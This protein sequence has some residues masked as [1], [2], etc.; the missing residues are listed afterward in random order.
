MEHLGVDPEAALFAVRTRSRGSKINLAHDA[1]SLAQWS[2]VVKNLSAPT[3][4]AFEALGDWLGAGGLGWWSQGRPS[5]AY[6]LRPGQ[7]ATHLE[8]AALWDS[9]GRPPITHAQPTSARPSVTRVRG[10]APVSASY[11][12]KDDP[13]MME[14]FNLEQAAFR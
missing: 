1:R 10:P 9:S 5:L 2:T 3:L 6:L 13:E 11:A 14:I 8:D 4:A 7:L 12:P